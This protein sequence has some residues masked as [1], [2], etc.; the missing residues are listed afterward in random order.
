[1]ISAILD[2]FARLS[3]STSTDHRFASNDRPLRPPSL[4]RVANR[5]RRNFSSRRAQELGAL[6]PPLDWPLRFHRVPYLSA[7]TNSHR[8]S[9]PQMVVGLVI[10]QIHTPVCSPWQGCCL[11]GLRH[12][13]TLTSHS[14]QKRLLSMNA[15]TLRLA[16]RTWLPCLV[17]P[18]CHSPDSI[19][20]STQL[21]AGACDT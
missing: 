5:S 3:G 7:G 8:R 13:S 20:G 12:P 17:L 2:S 1:M 4:P 19:S 15:V 21:S 6:R 11:S 9:N 10:H 18:P 16:V 14:S